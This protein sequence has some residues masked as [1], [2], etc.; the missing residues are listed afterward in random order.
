MIDQ[1]VVTPPERTVVAELRGLAVQLA[2]L[3]VISPGIDLRE[4]VAGLEAAALAHGVD[5]S[6]L[7]S[8][9]REGSDRGERFLRLRAHFL[10]LPEG[11][12]AD[13]ESRLAAA[14]ALLDQ[15]ESRQPS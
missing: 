13:F 11:E 6:V 8:G 2:E 4:T 10:S 12:F 1:P 7:Y 5:A 3:A 9:F 14:H 15:D